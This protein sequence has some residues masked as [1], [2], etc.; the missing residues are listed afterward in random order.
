MG[1]RG[2]STIVPDYIL[3][4]GTGVAAIHQ[5]LAVHVAV[6]AR[7]DSGRSKKTVSGVALQIR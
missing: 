2:P 5:A 4:Q 7:L 3:L 1:S 6:Y